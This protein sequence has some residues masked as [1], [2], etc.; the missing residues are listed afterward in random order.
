MYIVYELRA[1]DQGITTD[2]VAIKTA[3][4]VYA[5]SKIYELAKDAVAS[6]VFVHTI[7]CINEHGQ[8]QFGTPIYFEHIPE[9]Q[10]EES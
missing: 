3:N 6:N 5:Q 8:A 9:P 4:P 10:I 7:L 1:N 2:T